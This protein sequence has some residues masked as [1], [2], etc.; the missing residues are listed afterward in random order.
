MQVQRCFEGKGFLGRRSATR[1]RWVD[2][3]LWV[4]GPDNIGF[5]WLDGPLPW[6]ATLLDMIRID[7]ELR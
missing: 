6:A 7:E 4:Y 1:S 2:G 3:R 5:L